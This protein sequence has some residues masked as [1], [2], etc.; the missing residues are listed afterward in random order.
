MKIDLS[1]K[2]TTKYASHVLKSQLDDNSLM[3]NALHILD[4][5]NYQLVCV[6]DGDFLP[7]SDEV[8]QLLGGNLAM[9]HVMVEH[10]KAIIFFTLQFR[11]K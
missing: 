7:F 4:R 10:I 8:C 2:K 5:L 9:F 6:S 3:T 1:T 11:D